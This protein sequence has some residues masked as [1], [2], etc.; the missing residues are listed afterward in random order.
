MATEA[1]RTNALRPPFKSHTPP[2]MPQFTGHATIKQP[3]KVKKII[4]F[5]AHEV[6]VALNDIVERRRNVA[7][8]SDMET[9]HGTSSRQ[10]C[11]CSKNVAYQYFVGIGAQ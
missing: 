3:R 11:P 5:R 2:S 8:A 9:M 4:H 7:R 10:L 6:L 1:F